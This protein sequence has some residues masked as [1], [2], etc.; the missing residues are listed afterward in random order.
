MA[1]GSGAATHDTTGYKTPQ[2][3]AF[4][5][6]YDGEIYTELNRIDTENAATPSG[7]KTTEVLT[8]DKP[9]S[10]GTY[11]S[12]CSSSSHV[13]SETLVTLSGGYIKT[14]TN[15]CSITSGT[16][17]EGDPYVFS[18]SDGSPTNFIHLFNRAQFLLSNGGAAIGGSKWS[19]TSTNMQADTKL[20]YDLLKL[21]KTSSTDYANTAYR[22][23]N[24]PS[25]SG[26]A[27]GQGDVSFDTEVTDCWT[28]LNDLIED[29]I[30]ERT[31]INNWMNGAQSA[32][33][34]SGNDYLA[35]YN[36][37]QTEI[38]SFKNVLKRRI[39]EISNRIGFVNAKDVAS[40]GTTSSPAKAS[41]WN[42]SNT[43]FTAGF[44]GYSF[45]G[46][47]GYANT[48][49]SHANFLAGKKINLLGKVLKA[50][51]AVQAMYD[52]VTTKRS[53]YYEYN[54]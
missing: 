45:N 54:Q 40:G 50:I 44:T 36:A 2:A 46:G 49:Y 15:S 18:H 26:Y 11:G 24:E 42:T 27:V 25:V 29:H 30:A 14:E 13:G 51:T 1:G 47:S 43:S 17:T 33:Y 23:P 6:H 4:Q 41:G 19:Y 38:A 9:T 35:Y 22:D 39:T 37:F 21:L 20:L 32:D 3:G 12:S 5:T 28:A 16:G 8:I 53:E 34:V 10:S 48:I 52:S 7:M 31:A